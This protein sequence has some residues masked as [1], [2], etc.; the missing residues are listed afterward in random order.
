ME[1]VD[2]A[3]DKYNKTFHSVTKRKPVVVFLARSQRINYQDIVDFKSEDHANVKCEILWKQKNQIKIHN[4]KRKTPKRYKTDDVVYKKNKQ[5]KSKDKHL[6]EKET[7][8]KNNRITITTTS[9]KGF[10]TNVSSVAV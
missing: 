5:I 4:A 3:V 9:G 6:F 7:V 8:A 2:I 1:I 10:I